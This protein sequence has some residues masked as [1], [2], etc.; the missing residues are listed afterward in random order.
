MHVKYAFLQR[1]YS[2]PVRVSVVVDGGLVESAARDIMF[3]V[4]VDVLWPYA[5]VRAAVRIAVFEVRGDVEV[6]A[7]VVRGVVLRSWTV[8]DFKRWVVARAVFPFFA[9]IATLPSR[10]AASDP[11]VN[12]RQD[13]IKSRT[14]LIFLL[15]C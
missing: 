5:G 9:R 15:K 4:G 14:F 1:S 11:W 6:R 3:V 13:I 8:V 2:A 10:T 12:T 7:T